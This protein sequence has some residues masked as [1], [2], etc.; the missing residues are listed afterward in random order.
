[1]DRLTEE[2]VAENNAR[3]RQANERIQAVATRHDVEMPV[4]F[5]C[6]C[7]DP[8]CVEILRIERTEYEAVRADPRRF[9]SAP[10]HDR[11]DGSAARVVSEQPGWIVVEKVGH[12]GE[13][14]EELAGEPDSER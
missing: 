7:A 2:R 1:M 6:E 13:V 8:T 9:L 14:A 11:V 5:L 12:A 3:F 10:G 4:P